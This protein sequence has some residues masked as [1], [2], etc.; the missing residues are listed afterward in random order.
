MTAPLRV[1]SSKWGDFVIPDGMEVKF[2]PPIHQSWWDKL[3]GR[4]L[5]Y[6]QRPNW[7]DPAN[8]NFALWLD[9]QEMAAGKPYSN[10]QLVVSS[11]NQGMMAARAGLEFWRN[12][13]SAP[14]WGR[15]TFKEWSAGWC[16]Q[17]RLL[18]EPKP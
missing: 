18:N 5:S 1:F 11:Y 10:N 9:A 16:Y 3:I 2:R 6:V 15:E 13:Y 12:P 14:H 17:M 4:E 8:E 7:N